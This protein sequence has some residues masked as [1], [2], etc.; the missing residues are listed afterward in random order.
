MGDIDRVRQAGSYGSVERYAR[1][2]VSAVNPD[3]KKRDQ[4]PPKHPQNSPEEAL[5]ELPEPPDNE[6]HINIVA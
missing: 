4:Q 6:G 5:V 3:Q 1:Q 2:P